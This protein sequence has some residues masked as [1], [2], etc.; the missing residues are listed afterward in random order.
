MKNN[1]LVSI[2][3][4]TQARLNKLSLQE[5]RTLK[6][7][8]LW[9]N[10]S[11]I[12]LK[13]AVVQWLASCKPLTAKNYA[14]G[15]HYLKRLDLWSSWRKDEEITSQ[16]LFHEIKNRYNKDFATSLVLFIQE[17]QQEERNIRTTTLFY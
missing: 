6:T 11:S 10:L 5:A 17:I 2:S 1:I 12:T 3:N 14:K 15:N 9:R 16:E 4:T 7:E 13:E 8:A